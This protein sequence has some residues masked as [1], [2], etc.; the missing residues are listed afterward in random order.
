MNTLNFFSGLIMLS[1]SVL[2]INV[3]TAQP[4]F[5]HSYLKNEKLSTLI[6]LPDAKKG[7]YRGTRF[8]WSGVVGSLKFQGHEYFSHWLDKHD[9]L[10]HESITGPVEAFVP[11]GY[12]DA[13]PGEIFTAIG[14]GNLRKE[15]DEPYRFATSYKIMDHGKWKIRKSA[16]R[17]AF[18]HKLKAKAGISYIYT[19]TLRLVPGESTMIL[20]HELVNVGKVPIVT[21]VYNHNFFVI[22]MEP[23]GP[24]I[25]TTFTQPIQ[26]E[27]RGFGE[28]IAAED[29]SLIFSRGLVKGESVY[30]PEVQAIGSIVPDYDITIENQKAR[31]GVRIT[32]D[33]S[34][35]KLVYWASA[36]TAC[37]EP[38]ISIDV[39]PGKSQSWTINYDFFAF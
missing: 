33:Q 3:A 36:T 37:P 8:D 27:G 7:F 38:Y 20:E 11:I 18:T 26:A 13:K 21:S 4:S 10:V 31:V 23:T 25:V 34:L 32:G 6:Y 12:E 39:P 28:L 30:T 22:D 9:P 24:N 14:I 29:S 2:S 15:T 35:S 5:P 17:I 19:K 16:D 1:M